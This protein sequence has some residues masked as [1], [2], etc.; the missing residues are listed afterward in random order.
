MGDEAAVDVL[1]I[2][3]AKSSL[4]PTEMHATLDIIHMA[5]EH[6]VAVTNPSDRSPRAALFLL[7]HLESTTGDEAVK[8]RIA[9]ETTFFRAVTGPTA[10]HPSTPKQ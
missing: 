2:L 9:R 6:P 10:S 1:K 8:Q 7:R 3:S 5:F 4:T